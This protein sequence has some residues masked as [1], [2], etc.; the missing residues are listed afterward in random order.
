VT[1]EARVYMDAELMRLLAM[2]RSSE[3][4]LPPDV[5][6]LDGR[7][8]AAYHRRLGLYRLYGVEGSPAVGA[9]LRPLLDAGMA[10]AVGRRADY[11]DR[12]SHV[13]AWLGGGGP[14]PVYDMRAAFGEAAPPAG[15]G[16]IPEPPAPKAREG[17]PNRPARSPPAPAAGVRRPFF[18]GPDGRFGSE[19]ADD[20]GEVSEGCHGDLSEDG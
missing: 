14:L 13:A 12:L 11:A 19:P 18:R 9:M 1:G 7:E 17:V 2:R 15:D 8:A 10:A 5:A 3:A 20:V 6:L 16:G 4:P